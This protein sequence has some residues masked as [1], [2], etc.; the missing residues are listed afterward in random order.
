VKTLKK[1]I[2][3]R[4]TFAKFKMKNDFLSFQDRLILAIVTITSLVLFVTLMVSIYKT[5]NNDK[6]SF[7]QNTAKFGNMPFIEYNIR[8]KF[9]ECNLRTTG[10]QG[11]A[12]TAN[13]EEALLEDGYY[14]SKRNK[15][16][17]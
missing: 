3:K 7:L 15:Y 5:D 17:L 16:E 12:F 10:S 9:N 1:N 14:P 11:C 8:K 6:S 2:C 13:I 4:T